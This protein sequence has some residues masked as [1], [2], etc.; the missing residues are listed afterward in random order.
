M[1]GKKKEKEKEKKEGRMLY[2]GLKSACN[3]KARIQK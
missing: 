1:Y 2:R 3:N